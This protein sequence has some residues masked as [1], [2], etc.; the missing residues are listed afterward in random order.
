MFQTSNRDSNLVFRA[1][2]F[3]KALLEESRNSRKLAAKLI[4]TKQ[5]DTQYMRKMENSMTITKFRF[6]P[7]DVSNVVLLVSCSN[8]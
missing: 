5:Y 4:S 1:I 2:Y 3:D 7:F 8:C 6:N